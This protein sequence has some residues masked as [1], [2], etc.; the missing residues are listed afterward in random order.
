MISAN[1]RCEL[2]LFE[3]FLRRRAERP[4]E[5]LFVAYG[6]VYGETVYEDSADSPTTSE[7]D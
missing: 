4:E 3:I 7:V 6:E 5:P 2:R 1:D